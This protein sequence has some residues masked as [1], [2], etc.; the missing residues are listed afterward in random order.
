MCPRSSSTL[1][2]ELLRTLAGRMPDTGA[3]N[4]RLN[5]DL[6]PQNTGPG[7]SRR[8]PKFDV[9]HRVNIIMQH[10]SIKRKFKLVWRLWVCLRILS[11]PI[12]FT[13][14]VDYTP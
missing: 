2:S 9:R 8:S 1:T 4:F 13:E 11:F 5:V 7:P 6:V 14:R 12:W 3:S 10:K